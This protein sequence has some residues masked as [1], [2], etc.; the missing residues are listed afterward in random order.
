MIVTIEA[1]NEATS[2]YII[3]LLRLRL[4]KN[5]AWGSASSNF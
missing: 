2:R 4:E 1:R 5:A 3:V